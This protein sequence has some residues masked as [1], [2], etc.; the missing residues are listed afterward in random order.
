MRPWLERF[1][2]GKFASLPA[3]S[4]LLSAVISRDAV[5]QEPGRTSGKAWEGEL[6]PALLLGAEGTVLSSVGKPHF[7]A[8]AAST[9]Q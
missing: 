8:S 9:G 1:A 4:D 6:C 5:T 2:R 7:S 3:V